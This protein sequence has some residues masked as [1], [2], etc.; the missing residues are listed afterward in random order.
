MNNYVD[1][2]KAPLFVYTGCEGDI[3][4]DFEAVGWL[5]DPNIGIAE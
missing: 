4:D 5:T 1:E 2:K 3:D